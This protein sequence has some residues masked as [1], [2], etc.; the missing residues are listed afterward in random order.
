MQLP[1]AKKLERKT[2][3]LEQAKA[4]REDADAEMKALAETEIESLTKERE[5]LEAALTVAM[6][7]KDPNDHKNVIVEIRAGAGGDEAALFAANLFR[8]Y[9]RFAEKRN[10]KTNTLSANQTGIGGFKEVIFEVNGEDVYKTLKYEGGVHRVQRVPETE[11]SGR[12]HTSTATVAIL[13]QVD[14]VENKIKQEDLRIDVFRASGHG[15]QSVNTTDSA[16]RI[17][18]I[19]SGI[20]VS[21]QDEKSQLKNKEKAMKVLKTRVF[22]MEDEKARSKRGDERRMMVGTGDRSEKIR[23]YNE[24]QDRVTD[25]RI[26]KTIHGYSAV[27]D[28]NLDELITDLK[29]ADQKAKLEASGE[30][31]A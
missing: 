7:P 26:K 9:S 1:L 29:T 28:G 27:L 20:V 6:L 23:T 21:M 17:T 15:G 3:A 25:H 5:D 8:M 2:K 14:D 30:E 11:K 22:E 12:I 16:V 10:W 24:P 19:P 4:M 13:P 31:T 18:H